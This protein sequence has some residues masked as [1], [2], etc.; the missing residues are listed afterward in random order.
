MRQRLAEKGVAEASRDRALNR[1]AAAFPYVFRNATIWPFCNALLPHVR[2]LV[3]HFP[4]DH[5]IPELSRLLNR[6][7]TYL[8]GHGDAA[9]AVPLFRRALKSRERSF[10]TEHPY[11]LTS[12][13]NLAGCLEALGD[14]AQALKLYRRALEGRERVLGAEHPDTLGSVNNLAGYLETQSYAA[15]ALKLYRRAL[16]GI[17]RRF[18]PDHPSTKTIRGNYERVAREM[19]RQG[20]TTIRQWWRRM[21]R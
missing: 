12:V 20:G 14:A 21:R 10:G 4:K 1:M 16:E 5:S 8:H 6:T 7:G 2:S 18:G 19:G 9:G 11:T 3:G 13:N 15:Q 17:E